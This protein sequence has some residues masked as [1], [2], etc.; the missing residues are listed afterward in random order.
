[1]PSKPLPQHFVQYIPGSQNKEGGWLTNSYMH[2]HHVMAES[3]GPKVQVVGALHTFDRKQH[4]LYC[5][6]LHT[7]W[8]T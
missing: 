5:L 3:Q 1:M 6:E 8:C 2:G 4:F 7:P